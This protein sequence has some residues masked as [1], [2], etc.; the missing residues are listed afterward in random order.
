MQPSRATDSALSNTHKHVRETTRKLN[1]RVLSFFSENEG[2]QLRLLRRRLVVLVG[3]LGK[4]HDAQIDHWKMACVFFKDRAVA[5][6]AAFLSALDQGLNN[7]VR[8]ILRETDRRSRSREQGVEPDGELKLSLVAAE[9][10]D[11]LLRRDQLVQHFNAH[12]EWALTALNL[13]LRA[14]FG[15]EVANLQGNPYRPEIV[16]QAFLA[17]LKNCAFDDNAARSVLLAFDPLHSMDLAPLYAELD[18]ILEQAGISEQAPRVLK[19]INADGARGSSS[20][21]GP[22]TAPGPDYPGFVSNSPG[23][24]YGYGAPGYALS[25]FGALGHEAS[26]YVAPAWAVPSQAR[27]FLAKLGQSLV[28]SVPGPLVAG[29]ATGAMLAPEGALSLAEDGT[30]GAQPYLI[31]Y[32]EE[33]QASAVESFAY[34]GLNADLGSANVLRVMRAHGEIRS[35]TEFDRGTVDALAEVFDFVFADPNIEPELKVLI[36]RLQIPVLKAALLDRKFFVSAQHPARRL[37]NSLAGAAVAWTSDNGT[38]DALYLQIEATVKRV[39]AEFDVDVALF[40]QVQL[41]FEGFLAEAQK[42]AKQQVNTLANEQELEEALDAA[43]NQVDDFLHARI[44]AWPDGQGKPAF[45]LP[46]LTTQWREVLAQA[47]LHQASQ[48][49]QWERLLSATDQLLWSTQHKRDRSERRQLVELLPGLVQQLNASLDQQQWG[50][51]EREEFTR[52]LIAAHMNAIRSSPDVTAPPEPTD[53]DLRAGVEAVRQ[54]DQRRTETMGLETDDF[55]AMAQ[56]F[57]R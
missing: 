6:N 17:A 24:A 37:I 3:G 15:R 9:E 23:L 46:F 22:A 29:F 50:G 26:S 30:A 42:Q 40:A 56:A 11:R 54:L 52:R 51:H 47:L 5:F 49:Q 35:A 7:E 32:L 4:H 27:E 48:P 38:Q 41:E 31:A 36:G 12:Y 43:R 53:Q 18:H 28:P 2:E 1:A 55:A 57:T 45:L 21:T 25:G 33:L 20:A 10:M 44:S 13:R 19:T 8:T 39:L 16:V 14:L 34:H